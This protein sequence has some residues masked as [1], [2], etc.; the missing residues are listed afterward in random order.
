MK[1]FHKINKNFRL[2]VCVAVGII[3]I[4]SGVKFLGNLFITNSAIAFEWEKS[5]NVYFP[6]SKM[7]SDTD[8]S[9]VFP[10]SRTILNAETFGPGAL[11]ALL[12]GTI[13]EEKTFGYFSALNS[14][15]LIQKFEIKNK[16]AYIDFDSRLNTKVAGSCKITAIKAQIENTLNNLP[17]IDSVVISVN[18]Q[19]KSILEP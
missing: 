17:D 2:I 14:G 5:V 12:E 13:S 6:N 19:T 7:G 15:I 18:G 1:K 10:V 8:C 9:K 11:E 16:V 4:L 3:V